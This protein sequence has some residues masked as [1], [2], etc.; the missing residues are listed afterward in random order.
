MS[1]RRFDTNCVHAG[2]TPQT[3]DPQV[4]PLVQS[5]TYRYYN[6]ADVAALFDLDSDMFMYSR[7][8]HPDEDALE[9]KLTALEGGAAAVAASSGMAAIFLTI[10]TL[11]KAGDHILA[12]PSIYGGTFNLF[13]TTLKRFGIDVTFVDQKSSLEE[14][15]SKARPETRLLFGETIAN[16]ALHV[17]DFEKFSAAAKQIGVPLV[18]DNTLASPFLCR[19][20]E[21]GAD[22]VIHATTKWAD[23]QATSMG[24][25]IIDSGKF[26]WKK[27][28]KYPEITE[29]DESYHGLNFYEKFGPAAFAMKVRACALRDFGS[30]IA[31]MNS[32]LT[33]QGLQHLHVRMNRHSESALELAKFLQ[34]HPKIEWVYYPGLEGNENYQLT[35][36]YLPN[37][38]GGVLSFAVKGGREAG[39]KL[40]ENLKLASVV[41]HVG[42]IHTCVLHPASTTHRQLS[43]ADQIAAG[44]DPGLIRASVGLE[45]I[46]DIKEDFDQ[47]LNAI[48]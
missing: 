43:E 46:E 24:G 7:I 41:V 38:A 17:L 35:Q 1:E 6:A 42:D 20:I 37:G 15:V 27:D 3:G 25:V 26:D 18:I 32:W 31:P 30:C 12:S 14:I 11:C 22:I 34:R 19:P 23:G 5:T 4:L 13:Q 21:H 9:K 28:G 16:P 48:D 8:G 39:E 29:P 47:A 36:K 45:D 44:I 40:L 2:Y 33:F 10:S